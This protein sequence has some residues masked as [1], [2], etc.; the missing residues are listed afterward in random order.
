[1]KPGGWIIIEDPDDSRMSDGGGPLGPGMSTFVNAWMD[2]L[3]S[4]GAEPCFGRYLEE[5][6]TYLRSRQSEP[7]KV[8]Q[9]VDKL[10][11]LERYW[12]LRYVYISA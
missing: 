7:A 2:I 5:E 4:R 11:K 8:L 9:T 10:E 1:M 12:L 3:R 6:H